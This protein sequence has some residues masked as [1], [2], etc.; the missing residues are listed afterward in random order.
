MPPL[1]QDL[2]RKSFGRDDLLIFTE[3]EQLTDFL[4]T[5]T[6]KNQNLLMMS[7]GGYDGLDFVQLARQLGFSGWN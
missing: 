4:K 3:R 1:S 2:I 7:S 5:Q 6:W